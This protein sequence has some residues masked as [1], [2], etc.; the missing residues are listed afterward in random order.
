LDSGRRLHRRGLSIPQVLATLAIVAALTAVGVPLFHGIKTQ[1]H[2]QTTIRLKEM[3]LGLAAYDQDAETS[4]RPTSK[5]ERKA[6][7]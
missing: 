3:F 2:A 4:R 1:E 6:R 7:P 5:P